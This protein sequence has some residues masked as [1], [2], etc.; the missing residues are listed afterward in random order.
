MELKKPFYRFVLCNR[1]GQYLPLFSAE[2]GVFG[3]F[4]FA[5]FF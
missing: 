3:Q 1:L 4:F 5:S 2:N